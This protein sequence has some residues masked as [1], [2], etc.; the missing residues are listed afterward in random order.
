MPPV[1]VVAHHRHRA[2]RA[3]RIVVRDPVGDQLSP[4][5]QS[6]LRM[7]GGEGPD[8][9]PVLRPQQPLR[10]LVGRP[11]P[12]NELTVEAW[13]FAAGEFQ[14]QMGEDGV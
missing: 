5:H 7:K 11:S 3:F 2:L 8:R 13:V 12:Q 4:P 1:G 9:S 10:A 14:H 6:P